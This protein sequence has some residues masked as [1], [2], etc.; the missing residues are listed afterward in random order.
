MR[1][2]LLAAVL[3]LGIST[4]AI[5]GH[6]NV[7]GDQWTIGNYCLGDSVVMIREFTN[8][9]VRGGMETYK[10]IIMDPNSPCSDIRTEPGAQPV[11]VTLVKRMW[12]FVLPGGEELIM[13]EVVDRGGNKGYTWLLPTGH[14][15]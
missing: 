10:A 13:W 1:K 3:A 14:A 6:E 11:Q 12:S 7:V 2:I 5:A 15:V 9:I 8:A 4:P